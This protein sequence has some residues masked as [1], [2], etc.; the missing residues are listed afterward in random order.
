MSSTKSSS[1]P[2]VTTP[3]AASP[4][5]PTNPYIEELTCD[6][7][8]QIRDGLCLLRDSVMRCGG[9]ASD[10]GFVLEHH[11]SQGLILQLQGLADAVEY[12]AQRTERNHAILFSES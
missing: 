4:T 1:I 11:A 6:T 2:P 5:L 8:Y 12:E 9:Q 10:E 3:V 7:L